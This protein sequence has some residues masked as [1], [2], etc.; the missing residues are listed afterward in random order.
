MFIWFDEFADDAL[1][2]AST[3]LIVKAVRLPEAH[4]ARR[5]HLARVDWEENTS[6]GETATTTPSQSCSLSENIPAQTSPFSMVVFFIILLLQCVTLLKN[7]IVIFDTSKTIQKF[8][9]FKLA[10]FTL[11]CTLH[12]ESPFCATGVPQY[13]REIK[14]VVGRCSAM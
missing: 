1:E 13:T 2:A 10:V 8:P 11:F 9:N 7:E 5:P 3:G 4:L 12:F 14:R 6:Y